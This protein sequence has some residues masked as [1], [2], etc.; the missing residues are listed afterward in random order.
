VDGLAGV[1]TAFGD[2][3]VNKRVDEILAFGDFSHIFE[4][5]FG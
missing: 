2:I 5:L 4:P 1:P 3:F